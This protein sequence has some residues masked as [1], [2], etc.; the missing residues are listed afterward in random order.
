[1]TPTIEA[2]AHR[3]RRSMFTKAAA[4]LTASALLG[5]IACAGTES[6]TGPGRNPGDSDGA[7]QIDRNRTPI[8]MFHG[9]DDGAN[10]RSSPSAMLREAEP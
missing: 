9:H 2:A 7:V 8:A 5:T 1:M 10:R 4:V 6:S 3:G